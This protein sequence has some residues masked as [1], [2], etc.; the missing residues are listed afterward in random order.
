MTGSKALYWVDK[1]TFGTARG[2]KELIIFILNYVFLVGLCVM[3]GIFVGNRLNDLSIMLPC[4]GAKRELCTTSVFYQRP[5]GNGNVNENT[6]TRT[7]DRKQ[8]VLCYTVAEITKT[9]NKMLIPNPSHSHTI[10]FHSLSVCINRTH[11]YTYTY[12]HITHTYAHLTC[13]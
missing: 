12:T 13:A 5:E 10:L 4:K 6:M 8:E 1:I 11:I 3:H 9:C 2:L 7:E